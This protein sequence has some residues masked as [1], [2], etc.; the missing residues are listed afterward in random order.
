MGSW[1]TTLLAACAEGPL[2]SAVTRP[3]ADEDG[4]VGDDVTDD[5]DDDGLV[6]DDEV[7]AH[8]TTN[9]VPT[10]RASISATKTKV[11]VT[12]L[13]FIFVSSETGFWVGIPN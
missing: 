7:R 3:S 6:G 1:T 10:P 12:V 4:L 11:R 9:T 13:V 5:A 8:P 2:A